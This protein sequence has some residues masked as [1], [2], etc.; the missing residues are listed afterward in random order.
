MKKTI[1]LFLTVFAIS[2]GSLLSWS[3]HAQSASDHQERLYLRRKESDVVAGDRQQ[4][5]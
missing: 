5:Q 4:T 1:R 3:G 2:L